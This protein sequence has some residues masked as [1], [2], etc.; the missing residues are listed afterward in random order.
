VPRVPGAFFESP[1]PKPSAKKC[2]GCFIRNLRLGKVI[3][4]FWVE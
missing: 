1:T 3:K 2:E 4:A